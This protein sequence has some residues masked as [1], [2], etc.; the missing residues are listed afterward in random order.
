LL[1]LL[2]VILFPIVVVVRLVV[3]VIVILA[4]LIKLVELLVSIVII[5][6]VIFRIVIPFIYV[7]VEVAGVG[8]VAAVAV[9]LA[10]ALFFPD[11]VHLLWLLGTLVVLV[12]FELQVTGLRGVLSLVSG[13]VL[14]LSHFVL[15]TE[16]RLD[17]LASVAHEV[18]EVLSGHVFL[19]VR[20]HLLVPAALFWILQRHLLLGA[21]GRS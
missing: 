8:A 17:H 3:L 16:G 21:L 20:V 5:A 9:L 2:K 7:V 1:V 4:I 14:G 6:L 18:V 13:H 12:D 15:D 19:V 11:R 10:R